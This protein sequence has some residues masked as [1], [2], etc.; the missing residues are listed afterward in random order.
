MK[1]KN[2]SGI[3]TLKIRQFGKITTKK[4]NLRKFTILWEYFHGNMF[5]WKIPI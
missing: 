1:N 2:I 5:S 3:I 4:I